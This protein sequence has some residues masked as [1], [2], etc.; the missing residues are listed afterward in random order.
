MS[1]SKQNPFVGLRS[2]ESEDSH[3]YF[4]RSEHIKALL[5]QLH[6]HHF[7]VVVGSSGSGKSSLVRAG[8]VPHLEA[9]FLVQDRD[10]WRIA[11][12]KPGDAPMRQLSEALL[13][14]IGA[15][16]TAETILRQTQTL[17]DQGI[18]ALLSDLK[19]V[20]E[21]DDANL[22]LL[23]DQFEEIFRFSTTPEKQ[24]E[25]ADFVALLL[26]LVEQIETS[27]FVCLTMRSDF[28]GDCDTF[29]GLPEAMNK[30][31]FLVPRLT[32]SQRREA[33]T[34]P[35]HLSGASISN[36]LLDRMLNENID[37]RDDLPLLQH[38]MMRTWAE[39]AV[40]PDGPIDIPHYEKI[41]TIHAALNKHA[42]EA[43]AELTVKQ[44]EYARIIFQAITETD[45][46]NR[47]LRRPCHLHEISAICGAEPQVLWEI[48]QKFRENGR[49][50][51]LLSSESPN[52]DPLVDIS[53][54]S[55]IRQWGTLT[56]WVEVEAESARIY[57][58]L[59]ETAGLHLVGKAGLYQDVDLEVALDW[60]NEQ[61]PTFA[62]AKRYPGDFVS[63]DGFLKE[64]KYFAE[65]KHE[66][67]E[68][69]RQERERL[70]AEKA[71]MAAKQAE[72]ADKQKEQKHKILRQTRVFAGVIFILLLLVSFAAWTAKRNRQHAERQSL[73]ANYN[74]AKVF[75]EKAVGE[76]DKTQNSQ[77]EG[78]CRTAW[79]YAVAALQQ[80]I[81]P[82]STALEPATIG[83]LF[84]TAFIQTAFAER[85]S[86]RAYDRGHSIYSL[87]FSPET[88]LLAIA[89]SNDIHL[90]DLTSVKEI[91]SLEGH[92]N[93]VWSVAFSPDGKTL[94]SGSSDCTVKLWEVDSGKELHSLDGHLGK[95]LS[96]TFS[97]DSRTLASGSED[98]R[99]ILWEVASGKEIRCF[100]GHLNFVLSVAFS[101]DGKTLASGSDDCSVRLW[102]V[103]SGD[104]IRHFRGHSDRI[105]SVAFSP[106]GKTLASG[107]DDHSV[108]LWNVA[109][110]GERQRL[111]GH[112]NNVRSVVFS[113]DG[114]TLASSSNDRSVILWEVASGKKIRRFEGHSSDVLDVA[115]NSD[116][117]TL[118]S[119]SADSG[120]R[121]WDIAHGE[122][123]RRLKGHSDNVYSVVFSP[124]GK[125]LASSS[126]DSSV[127]LWEVASGKKI[128]HLVSHSDRVL[129][130]AFSSDGKTLASGSDDQSVKLWEVA[131]GKE[132]HNFKNHSG[133]IRSVAFSSD[134]KTLASGSFDGRV[135]LWDVANRKEIR[136]FE[137][138]SDNIN[139][140]VVFSPDGK[141]LASGSSNTSV[142]LWDVASG[143]EIRR[144]SDHSNSVNTVAFSP[145][146]RILASG[147]DDRSVVLWEVA[148]GK[149]IRRFKGHSGG[150]NEVVF[151]P[152]G[153]IL[154]SGSDDRS[155]RLWE[156]AS[157][158]EIRRFE[159]NSGKILSVA[160]SSDGK[161]L[162]AGSS[163]GSVILWDIRYYDLIFKHL[164]KRIF[165]SHWF[166]AIQ[167]LWQKQLAGHQ[168]KS[169]SH[170]VTL[171]DQD[172]YSNPKFRPLLD[173][174]APGQSKFD[175]IL[176]WVE[177]QQAVKK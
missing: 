151:S 19:P 31:Q 136:H 9:G 89:L 29:H 167:F 97:P 160:F 91:R 13:T 153:R 98:R 52:N 74:L 21:R 100:E 67:F 177:A 64:S 115:F 73:T 24:A 150:V 131:S 171:S 54:E 109:T 72:M 11:K 141:T 169:N 121:L 145:D 39:W 112:S 159:D 7:I 6:V 173:P 123:S 134:A 75:E 79:A 158:K 138:N 172:H 1:F 140:D 47:Q 3:Y 127:I 143:K 70:L 20:L 146:G 144:F 168:L 175:Q 18:S 170:Q 152:N 33:I 148:S 43:L 82:E 88:N 164:K 129:S 86:F 58:R 15:E 59:A 8:L 166:E 23:V 85:W 5:E 68:K 96:V 157:A 133:R 102:D 77:L 12:I 36:R 105:W 61:K 120:L 81:A 46:G 90:W 69:E 62:W 10:V 137:G 53:H 4:G 78:S 108:R 103:V 49:S 93:T 30:S 125:T 154:A 44:Q 107:S 56:S 122:E 165:W 2:F 27:I 135:I 42:D 80:E 132:I 83:K 110:G 51:L 111:R 17:K 99:V 95:V 87:A 45:A 55:L 38:A 118:I 147:S 155:V 163:D 117:K 162:T 84:D 130:V 35:I 37:T 104:Q 48:I 25:A 14:T 71:E 16:I 40:A 139:N 92:S 50:F 57:G 65:A 106:D 41:G 28:L 116:G 119:G 161:T 174:P 22:L 114:K 126:N 149:E 101:P 32:R 66:Q 142:I 60:W 63:A 76:I 113:P 26:R 94:A 124:D 34:G 156:V 128:S 176:A